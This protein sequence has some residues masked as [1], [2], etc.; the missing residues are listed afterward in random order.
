MAQRIVIKATEG[1]KFMELSIIPLPGLLLGLRRGWVAC[2]LT[3]L[4]R[5]YLVGSGHVGA[6]IRAGS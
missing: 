6:G 3:N 1:R 4:S 2:V 5:R